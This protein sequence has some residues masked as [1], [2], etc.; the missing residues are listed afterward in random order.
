MSR[1]S[2]TTWL[3]PVSSTVSSK[4][5]NEQTWIIAPLAGF[6]LSVALSGKPFAPGSRPR[7][8]FAGRY[9]RCRYR[10]TA[11]RAKACRCR[12]LKTS[13]V[14]QLREPLEVAGLGGFGR[15][16][17]QVVALDRGGKD[18]RRSEEPARFGRGEPSEPRR[19]EIGRRLVG[20]FGQPDQIG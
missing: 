14:E 13:L 4:R 8:V 3:A 7:A 2:V 19:L 5:A 17:R 16:R 6:T 18:R 1:S 20:G 9:P 11:S 15:P 12:R 10:R